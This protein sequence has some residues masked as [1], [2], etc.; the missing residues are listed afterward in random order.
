MSELRRRSE[1]SQAWRKRIFDPFSTPLSRY[2]MIDGN[3]KNDSWDKEEMQWSKKIFG[4]NRDK[5]WAAHLP[6][7]AE[8]LSGNCPSCGSSTCPAREVDSGKA[9]IKIEPFLWEVLRRHPELK[10]LLNAL[11]FDFVNRARK[12]Q[13]VLVEK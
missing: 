7:K 10:L 6:A 3:Q 13:Q 1:L 5:L 9:K 11:Q 8:P 12:V 2:A 4:F